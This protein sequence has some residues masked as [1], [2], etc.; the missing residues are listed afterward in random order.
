LHLQPL[1]D[2]GPLPIRRSLAI[3]SCFTIMRLGCLCMLH[4]LDLPQPPGLGILPLDHVL[5][6]SLRGERQTGLSNKR[7]FIKHLAG[8][9]SNAPMGE[10]RKPERK[11]TSSVRPCKVEL[12]C[13]RTG[14]NVLPR[15][16]AR[17]DPLQL[18]LGWSLLQHLKR[19]VI[20]R[21]GVLVREVTP[22][23]SG[24]SPVDHG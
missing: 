16:E 24:L 5:Q 21:T 6:W 17:V 10:S 12:R 2:L 1:G 3:A 20:V 11:L 15:R 9:M 4:L 14:G 7:H 19:C 18:L 13:R 8:I 23:W 22:C